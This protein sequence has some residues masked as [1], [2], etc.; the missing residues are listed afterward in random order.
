[1]KAPARTT[2]TGDWRAFPRG[3][4]R[5]AHQKMARRLLLYIFGL[6]NKPKQHMARYCGVTVFGPWGAQ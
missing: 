3:H 1:M 5:L 2:P 4:A 6:S